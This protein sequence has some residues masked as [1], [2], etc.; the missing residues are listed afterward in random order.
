VGVRVELK[1]KV[2]LIIAVLLFC[3]AQA[4]WAQT[5]GEAPAQVV[6]AEVRAG[7]V[8]SEAEF[9]GTVYWVEVAEVAAE[10]GGKVERV[11]FEEGGR[12]QAGQ[13]L[14][15][16][17]SDLL[18]Q[19]LRAKLASQQ[20]A[21][22]E[23]RKA[24]QD[25]KRFARLY[26]EATV[27]EQSYDEYRFQVLGLEKKVASLEAEAERL[28]LELDKSAVRA[29]FEGLIL[30]KNVSPGEW[31]S[32]GSAVASLARADSLEVVVNVPGKVVR[33]AQPGLEVEVEISG[34]RL[35]GRVL[36]VIPKGDVA[37]RT[38]PLKIGIES[39]P[40]LIEGM[41]AHLRLP[42]GERV[43]TLLVPRDA[44]V[45]P[46]GQTVVFAVREGRSR[47]VPVRVVGYEG[48]WAGVEAEGLSSGDKVIVKGNER[49]RDDQA[50]QIKEE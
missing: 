20:Q 32:P 47:Q 26:R 14:V 44:V 29:P 36:T 31:L 24:R 18:R 23:L 45:T 17:N 12:V 22:V 40:W 25:F 19:T 30:A 33:F 37:T 42:S 34:Q 9:V 16:V 39:R 6:A 1:S 7:L 48:V 50:V 46:L 21:Q 27:S 38:F 3:S 5:P 28:K 10:V 15:E 49:L 4:A 35:P 13:T 41:E 43:E 2:W 11:N 8:Q